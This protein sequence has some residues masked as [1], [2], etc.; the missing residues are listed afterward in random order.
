MIGRLVDDQYEII[1]SLGSGPIFDAFV[2]RDRRHGSDVSLRFFRDEF[3]E[4]HRFIDAVKQVSA[5]VGRVNSSRI[6]KIFGTTDDEPSGLIGEY[7]PGVTLHERVRKLAPFSVPH[8]LTYG[9]Q[10][11][12]GLEALH[13][14]GIIHGDVGAHNII[15]LPDENL[16]L[17]KAGLWESYSQSRRA[18]MAALPLMAPYLAPEVSAGAMPSEQS[19]LYSLGVVLFECL[20]G[21]LPYISQSARELM[22]MHSG[23]TI[24]RVRDYNAA[25]PGVLDKVVQKLLA[26]DPA[27]RY[28]SAAELEREL[29]VLQDAVRFGKPLKWPITSSKAATPTPKVAPRVGVIRDAEP[30]KSSLRRRKREEDP[31]LPLWARWGMFGLAAFA[32]FVIAGLLIFNYIQPRKVTIPNVTGSTLAEATNVLESTGFR[33]TVTS[34][35][36]SEQFKVNQV[37]ES[38]PRAGDSLAM[39]STIGLVVSTGSKFVV[40]PNLRGRTYD[41]ARQILE[42]IYL[43]IS[44]P[45]TRE[46]SSE[47]HGTVITQNPAPGS[48]LA[49]QQSVRITISRGPEWTGERP[50]SALPS[51]APRTGNEQVFSINFVLEADSAIRV[52][53][54]ATDDSGTRTIFDGVR[55]PGDKITAS[56]ESRSPEVSF[57]IYYNDRPVGDPIKQRAA[58]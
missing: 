37:I 30:K 22:Q 58:N 57:Q 16:K 2:A 40:V 15:I 44:E 3:R 1:Q 23:A 46:R 26:K 21:R 29:K 9:I 12:E 33:V 53:I 50:E 8:V 52:R 54:E 6:E 24:P 55:Q 7:D 41:E 5:R 17:Q 34:R 20:T 49:Q 43:T 11:C 31:D 28:A 42:E 19:D 27:E 35:E 4:E 45:V 47:P 10:I 56:A 51:F 25:V 48:K 39:G 36:P 13:A 14:K 32:V 38:N 18:G